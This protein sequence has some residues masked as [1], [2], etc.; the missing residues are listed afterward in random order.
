MLKWFGIFIAELLYLLE[1]FLLLVYFLLQIKLI[2]SNGSFN[3]ISEI[4]AVILLCFS[5][6]ITGLLAYGVWKQKRWSLKLGTAF[7]IWSLLSLIL[8]QIFSSLDLYN[9]PPIVAFIILLFNKK[10]FTN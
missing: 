7:A 3:H 5:L 8:S 4:I 6:V 9:I 2:L 10:K 1:F